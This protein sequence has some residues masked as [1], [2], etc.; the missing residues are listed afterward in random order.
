MKRH[1]DIRVRQIKR[2][3]L[4][5]KSVSPQWREPITETRLIMHRMLSVGRG[6]ER[7]V[8]S[9]VDYLKAIG[10]ETVSIILSHNRSNFCLYH[11]KSNTRWLA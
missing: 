4:K 2:V 5:R 1:T 8:I 11:L 10:E 7:Y 9:K 6:R 3:Y